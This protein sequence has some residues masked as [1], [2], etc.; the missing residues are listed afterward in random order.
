MKVSEITNAD[1]DTT[2]DVLEALIEHTEKTEPYAVN[3]ISAFREAAENLPAI[4]DL[5]G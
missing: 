5:Q 1:L 2:R 3:A 4:E